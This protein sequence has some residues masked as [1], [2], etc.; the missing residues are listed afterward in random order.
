MR[1]LVRRL[2]CRNTPKQ[3]TWGG[4]DSWP[5]AACT[6]RMVELPVRLVHCTTAGGVFAACTKP[7][8]W[9]AR[10]GK[11]RKKEKRVLSADR[12]WVRAR[13]RFAAHRKR[14]AGKWGVGFVPPTWRV[15]RA[16]KQKKKDGSRSI[17]GW[18]ASSARAPDPSGG[19]THTTQFNLALQFQVELWCVL[20]LWR[21]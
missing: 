5:A 12:T 7:A 16:G 11:Q 2:A 13:C 10:G 20:C 9:H 3:I 19:N 17:F 15:R 4:N 14:R 18:L 6:W 8:T 1:C 21:L